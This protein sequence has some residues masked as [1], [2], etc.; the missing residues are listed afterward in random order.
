MN[1]RFLM[2]HNAAH[3]LRIQGN[4]LEVMLR[5]VFIGRSALSKKRIFS[6]KIFSVKLLLLGFIIT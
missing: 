6:V 2:F 1:A 3:P 4:I 5:D